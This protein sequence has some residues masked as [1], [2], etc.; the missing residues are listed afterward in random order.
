[1][2][3]I[4]FLSGAT[5]SGSAEYGASEIVISNFTPTDGTADGS[6]RVTFDV[7]VKVLG[8]EMDIPAMQGVEAQLVLS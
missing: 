8:I 1:M 3:G 7:T 2:T 5:G 6:Y 4:D